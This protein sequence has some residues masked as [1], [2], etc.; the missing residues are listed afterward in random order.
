ME[1]MKYKNDSYASIVANIAT[2]S[3]MI[4][5]MNDTTFAFTFGKK[6][7]ILMPD[8]YESMNVVMI[9]EKKTMTSA[10]SPSPLASIIALMSDEPTNKLPPSPIVNM[11][12]LPKL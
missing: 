11:N 8:E 7:C 2:N 12:V 9:V 1:P 6:F 3:A 5:K 4:V 10:I